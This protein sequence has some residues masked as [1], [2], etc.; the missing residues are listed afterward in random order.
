MLNRKFTRALV[1]AITLTLLL[2]AAAQAQNWAKVGHVNADGTYTIYEDRFQPAFPDGTLVAEI[3]VTE[4]DG[5]VRVSR[6]AENGCR[7]EST[8]AQV[9]PQG[10]LVV[11]TELNLDRFR[12][13][14]D[15]CKARFGDLAF[16]G[17]IDTLGVKCKCIQLDPEA[18]SVVAS[19]NYCKRSISSTSVWDLLDWILAPWVR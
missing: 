12:C 8:L 1:G 18:T 11:S 6:W 2:S 19:G 7:G 13:V 4:L 16:C 10:S 3:A 17:D 5:F 14:D 9:G 15:G